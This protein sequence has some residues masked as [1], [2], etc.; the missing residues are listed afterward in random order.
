[1]QTKLLFALALIVAVVPCIAN[2]RA[3]Q[4]NPAAENKEAA[5]AALREKAFA[6]LK[7]LAGELGTLQSPENRA[8]IGSNIAGSLWPHDE[9]RARELITLVQ[10]D[11]NTGLRV[12]ENPDTEDTKT[13]LVFLKLR[14]DTIERIA[15]HDPELAYSFFRA[16]G[17]SS[18]KDL[19]DAVRENEKRLEAH[20]AKQLSASNPNLSLELARKMM[21]SGFSEDLRL[22][23]G[24]LNRKHKEQA[25]VLYKEI[26]RKLS[27]TD[28]I[29]DWPAQYFALNLA[30]SMAPPRSD[31]ATFKELVNLFIKVM[32]DNSCTRNPPPDD[33]RFEVCQRFASAIPLIAKVDPALSGKLQHW[34][35][36]GRYY[37]PPSVYAELTELLDYGSVD[38]MLALIV[39][40][41]QMESEI[42]F[43]AMYK[44]QRDGDLE[45]VRKIAAEFT[46]DPE[47]QRMMLA[48]LDKS[49]ARVSSNLKPEEVQTY[50]NELQST[51]Q[52][53]MYLASV[54][55]EMSS[56]DRKAA[57]KLLNQATEIVDA[58]KPGKDQT[59]M[60]L[61][62]A[63]VHS[64]EKSDRGLAM[65]EWLVPKLNEL[66]ASA[67]K[68]DGYDTHY[69]RDGEWNM[70][71]EGEL[72][73]LLT[74]LA[75]NATYFAWC[76]FDR[77]VSAAGQFE[78]PEIRIMAQLKLAQGIL[79]GP[80]KPIQQ[81]YFSYERYQYEERN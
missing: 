43:Y 23:L 46:A 50:L 44:A 38:D 13:L 53:V 11:I 73:S 19:P 40:Y 12:P 72:G 9:N 25:T 60:Q 10:Q 37:S 36:H 45:R 34:L 22:L 47:G 26:V 68:L 77:A 20:I 76:D 59:S 3:Q 29:T 15:K 8:R 74:W 27:D 65:M 39:E 28:F 2:V 71:A 67:A 66:V 52:K 17:V 78:R 57:L 63:A 18:E 64:F 14:A 35:T 69:L 16:T 62:L 30:N 48:R 33:E 56:T 24:R 4:T 81:G 75:Q 42:R 41:P 5:D 61:L 54:A 32:V 21:A 80:P 6:L 58:M 70:S 31:E 49:Q 55:G 7:S 1:L 51:E 79:A